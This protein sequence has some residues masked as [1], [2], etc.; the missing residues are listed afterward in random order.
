MSNNDTITFGQT[1]LRTW[2][3]FNVDALLRL[4]TAGE[5]NIP[6]KGPL[7]IAANHASSLDAPVL[8]YFLPPTMWYVGPGDFK[9]IF[10]SNL[11]V[12]WSRT[13]RVKRANSLELEGLRR[14]IDVLKKGGRL[15]I[16]PEGGTWEKPLH[17][18]KEGVAYLSMITQTPILPVGIGGAYGTWSEVFRL[19]RPMIS[20]KFGELIPPVPQAAHAHRDAVLENATRDLMDRIYRLLPGPDQKRYDELARRKYDLYTEIW[21]GD[22]PQMVDLPGRAALGEL[23]QKPNLLNPF[24]RNA[25]L[26]ID[27]LRFH[28]RRFPVSALQ[29]A[30]KSLKNTRQPS[31]QEYLEYRLGSEKTTAIQFALDALQ[32][33]ANTEGVTGISLKPVWR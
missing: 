19:K 32:Q 11:I 14:M 33:I 22:V 31:L 16:F 15:L 8:S 29:L 4:N 30:V 2:S 26:P 21:R 13:I 28:G 12:K 18:A 3:R 25:G 6:D 23:I 7:L 20:V 5:K 17:Q 9:L 10:P 27:P 1:L 24:V